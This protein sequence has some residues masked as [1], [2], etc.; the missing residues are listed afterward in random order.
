MITSITSLV[1]RVICAAAILSSLVA[2]PISATVVAAGVILASSTDVSAAQSRLSCGL[3]VSEGSAGP[4]RAIHATIVNC[5]NYPVR[6][7]VDIRNRPDSRC[8]YI[9]PGGV[10][11]DTY[12]FRGVGGLGGLFNC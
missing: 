5:N 7:K 12:Y 8:Y 9:P 6:W 1:N 3:N 2:S 10:I 11:R 4:F